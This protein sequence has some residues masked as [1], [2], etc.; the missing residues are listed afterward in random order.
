MRVLT[1]LS[2]AAAIAAASIAAPALAGGKSAA[3]G[4]PGANSTV[5]ETLTIVVGVDGSITINGT[6][7]DPNNLPP[8]LQGFAG[9]PSIIAFLASYF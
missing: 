8:E 4:A 5:V 7:V 3:V 2:F 1:S 9:N 6:P